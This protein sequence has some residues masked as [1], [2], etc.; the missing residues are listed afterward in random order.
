MGVVVEAGF[1]AGRQPG[2]EVVLHEPVEDGSLRSPWGVDV[3]AQTA[4][5][6]LGKALLV[7]EQRTS[8][9]LRP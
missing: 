9:R 3:G 8:R 4:G 7:R 6:D 1:A 2:F 5:V